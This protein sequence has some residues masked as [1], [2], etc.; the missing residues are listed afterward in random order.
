M[1]PFFIL[2][3]S[4]FRFIGTCAFLFVALMAGNS[5]SAQ[6]IA[7]TVPGEPDENDS[8]PVLGQVIFGGGLSKPNH[9]PVSNYLGYY[10]LVGVTL[11]RDPGFGL[12]PDPFEEVKKVKGWTWSTSLALRGLGERSAFSQ[13]MVNAHLGRYLLVNSSREPTTY[14]KLAGGLQAGFLKLPDVSIRSHILQE[15]REGDDPQLDLIVIENKSQPVVQALLMAELVTLYTMGK[16][17]LMTRLRYEY[18]IPL[19]GDY[20]VQSDA[21]PAGVVE[22]NPK[23]GGYQAMELTFA[24]PSQGVEFGLGAFSQLALRTVDGLNVERVVYGELHLGLLFGGWRKH[25]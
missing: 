6:T 13:G 11:S 8:R 25:D 1:R 14:I 24:V 21:T 4:H 3:K 10:G 5:V 7:K 9:A 22:L 2:G 18:G 16:E 19:I 20:Q 17:R 23:L 15:F 12:S